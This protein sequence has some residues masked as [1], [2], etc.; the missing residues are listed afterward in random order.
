MGRLVVL[1]RLE[2][3]LLVLLLLVV[4]LVVVVLGVLEELFLNGAVMRLGTRVELMKHAGLWKR[5]VG[6]EDGR[7]QKK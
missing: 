1:C 5:S 7:E 2:G 4:V 3:D 6:K